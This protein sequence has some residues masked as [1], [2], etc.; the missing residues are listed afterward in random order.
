M[1][2]FGER[3]RASYLRVGLSKADIA[4]RLGVTPQSVQKYE[5]GG[6]PDTANLE[7]LARLLDVSA[8]WLLTGRAPIN[9]DGEMPNNRAKRGGRVVP[10]VDASDAAHGVFERILGEYHTYFQCGGRSFIVDVWDDSNSPKYEIGDVVVVD[11]DQ[12]A[13]PG[14][15]VFASIGPDKTPI[16]G[17]YVKRA[18]NGQTVDAVEHINSVWGEHRIDGRQ[19]V[20]M[21]T[22]VEHA[23]SQD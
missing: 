23:S 2:S 16:I 5:A 14:R 13:T 17:R 4:R 3:F 6:K 20:I 10:K 19:S 12:P 7:K 15:M 21:G 11:P 18:N 22:I 8:D 9:D 1:S